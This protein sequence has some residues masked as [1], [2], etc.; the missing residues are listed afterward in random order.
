[1]KFELRSLV[2]YT[3]DALLAEIR[4]VAA[5]VSNAA[6]TQKTFDGLSRVRSGTVS[7]RFGS[8]RLALECAGLADRYSGRRVS[9]KM[10]L[11][12]S[13]AMSNEELLARLV[14]LA[15]QLDRDELTQDD[16]RQNTSFSERVLQRRFGSWRRA[17]EL[18]GLRISNF[19]RRY[20]DDE[21]FENLLRVWTHYGRQPKYEEIEQPPSTVGPTAYEKRFGSWRKTLAAFV[22]R[23]NSVTDTAPPSEPSNDRPL[24]PTTTPR[25]EKVPLRLRLKVLQRDRF[26]CVLCGDSPAG[27]PVCRLQVD[28]IVPVSKNGKTVMDNL[29]SL[30]GS[31]NIGRSN[32]FED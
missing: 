32:W 7:G 18:A 11:R 24:K 13:R 23:V 28:H 14:A 19:G 29:R 3:D 12:P 5:L 26:R 10:R 16:V 25:R 31:C 21:C 9:Q 27:N 20:T 1:V 8:W 15:H 30:C 6:L 2:E 22:E 4:R 17:L